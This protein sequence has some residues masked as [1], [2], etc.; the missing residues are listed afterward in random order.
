MIR[1]ASIRHAF[2]ILTA[3]SRG[4][5]NCLYTG[6]DR[7]KWCDS[8]KAY[9][10]NSRRCPGAHLA[11]AVLFISVATMIWALDLDTDDSLPS[12]D[13]AQ[14]RSQFGFVYGSQI[15]VRSFLTCERIT[16]TQRDSRCGPTCDIQLH[17]VS[18]PNP[19]YIWKGLGSR[20]LSTYST[21]P[22]RF[23]IDASLN[24]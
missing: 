21:M 20:A 2:Y 1:S 10:N 15:K 18:S 4:A 22:L 13:P 12:I 7:G 5:G 9:I 16:D 3:P 8:L 23:R 24:G 11:N 17:V 6:L 19:C 14:W